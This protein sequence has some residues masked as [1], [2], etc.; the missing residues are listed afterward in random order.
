MAK[1]PFRLLAAFSERALNSIKVRLCFA[2][3]FHI[4][5]NR[6]PDAVK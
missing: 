4:A 5:V 3:M 2:I 6:P 1:R